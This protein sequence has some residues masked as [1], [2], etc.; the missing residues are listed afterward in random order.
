MTFA[1]AMLNLYG[2]VASNV[3]FVVSILFILGLGA[4]GD[5]GVSPSACGWP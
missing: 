3:G 2:N 4:P 5:G 1:G